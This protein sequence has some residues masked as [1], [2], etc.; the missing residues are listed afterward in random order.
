MS[1]SRRQFVRNTTI[2]A[3]GA[4]CGGPAVLEA[5]ASS[6]RSIQVVHFWIKAFIPKDVFLSFELRPGLSVIPF[7]DLGLNT[8]QRLFDSSR[9][10]A[11]TCQ[12]KMVSRFSLWFDRNVSFSPSHECGRTDAYNLVTKRRVYSG[13]ASTSR[14]SAELIS[15]A[16]E[17]G[18]AIVDIKCAAG[19]PYLPNSLTPDIDYTGRV[20]IDPVKRSLTFDGKIDAYPAFEAYASFGLHDGNPPV[21][22]TMFQLRPPAQNTPLNL[23]GSANTSVRRMVTDSNRNGKWESSE[24]KSF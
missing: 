17:K 22:V 19:M 8:N 10:L 16:G 6:D 14:M 5:A 21:T 20:T 12:S 2:A 1:I 24:V 13:K 4:L 15:S 18:T 3:A 9:E 23:I 7:A 11:G